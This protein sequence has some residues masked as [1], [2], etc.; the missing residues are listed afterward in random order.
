MLT[1]APAE[2]ASSSPSSLRHRPTQ[3]PRIAGTRGRDPRERLA[4]RASELQAA[5]LASER[6][7]IEL[8]ELVTM[9]AHDLRSPLLT[10]EGCVSL[11]A[12]GGATQGGAIDAELL[13]FLREGLGRLRQMTGSLVEFGRSS[14]AELDWADCDVSEIVQGVLGDLRAVVESS[15]ARI[16]LH[17]AGT[18]RADAGQLRLVFQ[19]LIENAIK[20]AGPRRPEISV[21]QTESADGWTFCVADNGVGIELAQQER[22]FQMFRRG[23]EHACPGAGVGLAICRKIVERHGGRIWVESMA[24]AGSRFYFTIPRREN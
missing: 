16:D 13:Q 1:L 12:R 19:N 17:L 4:V 23:G 14:L 6:N 3:R 9:V 10:L 11:L 18:V 2:T 5:L 24:G 7:R 21:R 8:Q 22:V 20:Y 15:Q